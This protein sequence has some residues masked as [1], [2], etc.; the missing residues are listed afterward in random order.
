M[1]GTALAQWHDESEK[2]LRALGVAWTILRPGMFASNMLMWGV[3]AGQIYP[4]TPTVAELLGRPT[5]TFD[6]W[7]RENAAALK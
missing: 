7:L 2:R 6:E 3:K 4:P 5:G 1:A